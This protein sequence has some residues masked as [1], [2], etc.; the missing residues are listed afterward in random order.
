MSKLT[1]ET[2][3]FWARFFRPELDVWRG[4]RSLATVFWSYGV[5]VSIGLIVLHAAALQ[6][7]HPIEE[8]ILIAA[9]AVYTIWILAAIWRTT[10]RNESYWAKLARGL[11]V[12][13]AM[14]SVMVLAFLELD[15]AARLLRS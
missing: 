11:T 1:S 15:L 5:L 10:A 8:Q 12:A 3:G 13:W 14:N 2:D 6:R 4:R 9:S 7:Q